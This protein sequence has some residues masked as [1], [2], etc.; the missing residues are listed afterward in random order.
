M[1]GSR[2]LGG[3]APHLHARSIFPIPRFDDLP[4]GVLEFLSPL[5]SRRIVDDD[6][7]HG[8]GCDV[9]RGHRVIADLRV[10]AS[11]KEAVD[12]DGI[13]LA[14]GLPSAQ[15]ADDV[16]L[17]LEIDDVHAEN[18]LDSMRLEL[19]AI[20]EDRAWCVED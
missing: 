3:T 2:R 4:S 9:P 17:F 5:V 20:I 14:V 7:L 13:P 18:A 12:V 19:L 8:P 10:V 16:R 1:L 6:V 15:V 11:A